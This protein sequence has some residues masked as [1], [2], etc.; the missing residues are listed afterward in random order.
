[1][2]A[3]MGRETDAIALASGEGVRYYDLARGTA[4]ALYT[5]RPD[6]RAPL[7]SHIGMMLFK[8][9]VPVGY[10]GGWPFLGT[11]KIGVNVFAPFRGG[12]S[13]PLFG[14]VLR[15]YRQC[16]GVS[17]FVAEPSQFGGSN[18]EGLRSGA[19]WFYYRLGFRPVEPE[20]ARRAHE[21][22]SRMRAD[23]SYRTPLPRLRRFTGS[24][25]ELI[26]DPVPE[27]ETGR[28]SELVTQWIGA[29]FG[30]DRRAAQSA[31][32]RSVARALDAHVRDH[33]PENERQAFHALAPLVAQIP[34]LKA[35]PPSDKRSL[36]LLLR[37]K[38]AD[39]FRFHER[40]RRHRR[41][42]AA[43]CELGSGAAGD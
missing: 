33:W 9:A 37:A 11:C 31:A 6:R 27:I 32:T 30:G 8:N 2:L 16:F 20:S 26:V 4:L 40:L 39:E 19:F 24:D 22:W 34:S 21:E 29:R 14:Q 10:G 23:P 15:V 1:V 17:R 7:D 3:A 28:L 13:A 38:G 41:L 43:L 25:I 42:R 12:E 18:I 35:W 5:I 36:L